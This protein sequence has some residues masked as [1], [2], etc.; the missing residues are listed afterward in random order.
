[1][2][3]KP[4]LLKLTELVERIKEKKP[5]ALG[6][7]PEKKAAVLIQAA[8][9][10]LGRRIAAAEVG[11]VKVPGMGRFQGRMVEREKDGK[12]VNVK[13]IVFLAAKPKSKE[14]D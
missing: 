7:M 12:K 2:K 9:A 4:K 13:R 6:K 1:M 5:N 14:Q 8:L 10:E 11:V 3:P